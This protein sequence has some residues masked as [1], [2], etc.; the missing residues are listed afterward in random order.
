[1][2][3]MLISSDSSCSRFANRLLSIVCSMLG[4]SLDS[5]SRRLLSEVVESWSMD[6]CHFTSTVDSR[7]VVDCI[8]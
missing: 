5:T 3:L 4:E 8:D 7:V 1:M 2:T 6:L